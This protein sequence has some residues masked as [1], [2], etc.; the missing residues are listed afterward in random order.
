VSTV[1]N[2]IPARKKHDLSVSMVCVQGGDGTIISQ[3]R[4]DLQGLIRI[5]KKDGGGLTD[6]THQSK[7]SIM[8][9]P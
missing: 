7:D 2:V 3:G 1:Q 8:I 6:P 9:G 5:E 4:N